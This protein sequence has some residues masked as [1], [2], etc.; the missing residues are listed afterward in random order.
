[1]CR[2]VPGQLMFIAS[3]SVLWV[4]CRAAVQ[5]IE[6]VFIV[7]SGALRNHV[8]TKCSIDTAPKC[9]LCRWDHVLYHYGM[10]H[11]GVRSSFR[12]IQPGCQN[13]RLHVQFVLIH[14]PQ[15]NRR[16]LNHEKH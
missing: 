9:D 6:G 16:T 14:D 8:E 1:M 15:P 5:L 7:N 4:S 13:N 2:D 12:A 3:L 10:R 11:S